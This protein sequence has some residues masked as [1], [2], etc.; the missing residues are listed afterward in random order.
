MDKKE[1]DVVWLCCP[2]WSPASSLKQSSHLLLPKCWDYRHESPCMGDKDPTSGPQ[3]IFETQIPKT[4]KQAHWLQTVGSPEELFFDL[5]TN[6]SPRSLG[7]WTMA[8]LQAGLVILLEA[9]ILLSLVKCNWLYL[10]D[11]ALRFCQS[12]YYFN[13]L[14]L[15]SI[16]RSRKMEEVDHESKDVSGLWNLQKERSS[17]WL[18][19]CILCNILYNKSLPHPKR[20]ED[21]NPHLN[22]SSHCP[23]AE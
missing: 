17:V 8:L 21:S 7:S 18:F 3:V 23:L 22:E 1:K 10:N 5:S 20:S 14:R 15:A 13:L 2:G 16:S 9:A 12:R 19:I 4:H 6:F 11:V